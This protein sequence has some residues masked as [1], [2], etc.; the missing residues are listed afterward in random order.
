MGEESLNRIPQKQSSSMQGRLMTN[1][2]RRDIPWLKI[3]L[4]SILGLVFSVFV[5]YQLGKGQTN[6]P[7]QI[8][9]FPKKTLVPT[10]LFTPVPTPTSA[11]AQTDIT[12]SSYNLNSNSDERSVITAN[13]EIYTNDSLG[14]SFKYPDDLEVIECNFQDVFVEAKNRRHDPC[15]SGVFGFFITIENENRLPDWYYREY[16]IRES[17]IVIDGRTATRYSG[18]RSSTLPAPIEPNLDIILIP[19]SDK[20]LL[21][22]QPDD[23]IL[24][25]FKLLK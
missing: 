22:N 11:P 13:W 1:R 17:K 7:S 19:L 20:S 18:S 5:G 15:R 8:V 25:T 9:A 2:V 14:I 3:I 16:S 24:P 10:P 6:N 4:F 21:L 23:R 12:T